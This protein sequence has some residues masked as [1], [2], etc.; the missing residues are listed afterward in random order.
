MFEIEMLPAREGDCLWI[1]YGDAKKPKQ[2]LIDGGRKATAKELLTR[3][4]ALPAGQRTFELL[5][6][7]HID[8]DHIEGVLELLK[9]KTVKFKDIWF[10]AYFHLLNV[11]KF[12]AA[13][14]E[15]LSDALID[16][17]LPW[18]VK[19]KGKAVCLPA[20]GLKRIPLDGGMSLTLLSPDRD[21]LK[22][23]AP[24]WLKECE[25]AGL[26]ACVKPVRRELPGIES[27]GGIDI[28]TLAKGVFESD[29]AEPNGSSIAVL[30][31]YKK[32]KALLAADAHPDRLVA[33]IKT[34]KK[35]AKRLKL[36]AFKIAHHGSEGNVSKE[37]LEL[38]DC[39]RY[40]IST[41]GSYFKHPK[42]AAM[43]RIVKF[44]GENSTLYFNYKNDL[45]KIW[46]SDTYK[47]RYK[48]AVVFPEKKKNGSLLVAL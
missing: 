10:N 40:L 41:N 35:N 28:E 3:F 18:N 21:K 38:V 30:L 48:Y 2:L 39:R 13:Q 27:F 42:A 6:V 45:T 20:K 29:A 46:N 8:R 25:D 7:S 26:I 24:K 9:D 44:G 31:E 14:G 11:E 19:F 47:N 43:A 1:R 5:I 32:K 37:L 34:L 17:N 4:K 12:G 15:A 36:D 16:G 33:S 22:K 23:L